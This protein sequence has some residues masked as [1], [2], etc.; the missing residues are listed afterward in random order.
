[1]DTERAE[2]SAIGPSLRT[3]GEVAPVPGTRGALFCR[4]AQGVRLALRLI[5]WNAAWLIV[6][7]T[8]IAVAG[9]IWFRLTVPFATNV[10]PSQ[11]VPGVGMIRKPLAEFRHTNN[12]DVWTISRTNSLGF[13]DRE[14]IGV[15]QAS[16]SCHITMIG[17][18][19]VEAREVSIPDKFH[20]RLEA[21]MARERPELNV[22]TSAFGRAA[23]A[24][25]GQLPFYDEFARHLHPNM[26]VLV[27]VRND[28]KENEVRGMM[29]PFVTV[30]KTGDGTL[31]LWPPSPGYDRAEVETEIRFVRRVV[32][33]GRLNP[34]LKGTIDRLMNVAKMSYYAQ[35]L[36]AMLD[37]AV[38]RK[39][40][41]IE[42]EVSTAFALDQFK[43][44]TDRDGASLVILATQTMRSPR[45]YVF[46]R[47]SALAEERDI[48]VIDQYDYII[49]QGGRIEDAHWSHDEHW[50]VTGHRWAAE[51]LFEYLK[52]HPETCG[53]GV[54][55]KAHRGAS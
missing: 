28:F 20:V 55:G 17:D 31:T 38:R 37:Q 3:E 21:L 42:R 33:W 5:G 36:D 29:H 35:Y 49:R 11:F 34:F 16:E 13:L 52:Q 26:V 10:H 48:P 40:R 19:F 41:W 30:K 45:E 23:T 14:P 27:F 2:M 15:E 12:V 9:E 46:N 18:S 32:R 47:L 1:M 43:E 53:G 25:V 8:L 39:V 4:L 44:R 6:G 24:Q 51:A 54:A 7:L 22:T 50:N